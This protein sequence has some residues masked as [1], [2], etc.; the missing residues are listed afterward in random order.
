MVR[1]LLERDILQLMIKLIITAITFYYRLTYVWQVMYCYYLL[2]WRLFGEGAEYVKDYLSGK[3][4]DEPGK[5]KKMPTWLERAKMLQNK[6]Q[7]FGKSSI[8]DTMEASVVQAVRM[9]TY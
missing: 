1:Y 2:G 6:R 7:H 4:Q 5:K 9:L 8:F 3:A